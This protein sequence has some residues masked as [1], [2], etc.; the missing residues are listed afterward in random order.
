MIYY[1][2]LIC[3]PAGFLLQKSE[4][5][6][7]RK[8]LFILIYIFYVVLIGSRDTIGV[9]WYH[10]E[11]IYRNGSELVFNFTSL[12]NIGYYYL[13]YVSKLNHLSYEHF[14][15]LMAF[16][17]VSLVFWSI[18]RSNN[19]FIQIAFIAPYFFNV[20]MMNYSR[21]SLSVAI[22]FFL[23]YHRDK[24]HAALR[25]TFDLVSISIHPSHL[26]VFIWT[27]S[28]ISKILLLVV[29]AGLSVLLARFLVPYIDLYFETGMASQGA[30]PRLLVYASPFI[31]TIFLKIPVHPHK[32]FPFKVG[33]SIALICLALIVYGQS[34]LADRISLFLL[35]F[36][37]LIV[38]EH[39]SFSKNGRALAF[40]YISLPL[41][42]FIFWSIFSYWSGSW[43]PYKSWLL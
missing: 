43:Y 41:A 29:A 6:Y 14:N 16:I 23:V 30:W 37:S 19:V 40:F 15:F 38:G 13:I 7:L 8:I 42:L 36:S 10:Y 34:T 28:K 39:V 20:A 4:Y 17:T 24:L 18:R 32:K 31:F 33:L 35:P 12:Q 27:H 11:A 3:A 22:L 5:R 21:Q 25:A 26:V 9:D 2:Y 1:F